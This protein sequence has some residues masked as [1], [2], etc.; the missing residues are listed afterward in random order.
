[1]CQWTTQGCQSFIKVKLLYEHV[2]IYKL[3]YMYVAG[4]IAEASCRLASA[5]RPAYMMV[6]HTCFGS[7][8]F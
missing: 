4:F 2:L 6:T 7:L 3:S 5:A 1:M 8:S